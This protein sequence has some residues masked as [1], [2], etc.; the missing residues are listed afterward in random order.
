[1][2]QLNITH[3]YVGANSSSGT[4]PLDIESYENRKWNPLVF[5]SNPSFKLIKRMGAA[6]LFRVL[7]GNPEVVYEDSFEY[8]NVYNMGWSVI[9]ANGC[10]FKGSGNVSTNSSYAYNGTHNLVITA[11]N[12]GGLFYANG[13]YRAIYVWNTSSVTLSFYI[14]A[15]TGFT[16]PD[17]LSISIYNTSWNQSIC[18]TTPKPSY[19][20]YNSTVVLPTSVGHFSYNISDIWRIAYNATL[21]KIFFITIQN[22]DFDCIENIGYVDDI[23]V[24]VGG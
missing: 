22:V 23:L 8:T 24:K 13:I 21:P 3:V 19:V 11:K 1:M 17:T 5:L 9:N 14:N 18:F 6:Y 2:A 4:W 12:K 16:P 15:T 20:E 10:Q 7:Y